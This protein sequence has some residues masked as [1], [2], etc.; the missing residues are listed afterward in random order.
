LNPT[1]K[2]ILEEIED[3][4]RATPKLL[5]KVLNKNKQYIVDRLEVIVARNE[6]VKVETGVYD[7][8][9]QAEE[10]LPQEESM[11]VVHDSGE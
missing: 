6:L 10:Y 4:G 3:H 1:D 11:D 9:E 5:A 7:V 2:D 8:P